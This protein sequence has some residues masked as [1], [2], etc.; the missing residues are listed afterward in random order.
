M[1]SVL[2]PPIAERQIRLTNTSNKVCARWYADVLDVLAPVDDF[3]VVKKWAPPS[4]PPF[5]T[6]CSSM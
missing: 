2:I 5:G 1:A 3:V 6:S 4:L